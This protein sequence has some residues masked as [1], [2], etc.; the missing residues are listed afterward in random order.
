MV[1]IVYY[2]TNICLYIILYLDTIICVVINNIYLIFKK[3]ILIF[4]NVPVCFFNTLCNDEYSNL[5]IVV[6][7]SNSSFSGRTSPPIRNSYLQ[8]FPDDKAKTLAVCLSKLYWAFFYS[9]II[10]W[11]R[12]FDLWNLNW[13]CLWGF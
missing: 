4:F 7:F 2:F 12:Q 10:H 9:S 3:L 1:H 13:N 5:L 6:A 11:Y 8:L